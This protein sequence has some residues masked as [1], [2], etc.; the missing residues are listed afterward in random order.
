MKLKSAIIALSFF[1]VSPAL[2]QGQQAPPAK[3]G[4]IE[5]TGA[6]AQALYV[7]A[8]ELP[9]KVADPICAKIQAAYAKAASEEAKVTAPAKPSTP[10][11][12]KP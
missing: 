10:A 7:A 12:T 4:P 8:L 11:S 9:K 6:E 3:V 1:A 2:A 5:F